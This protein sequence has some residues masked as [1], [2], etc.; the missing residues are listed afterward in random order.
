M[1]IKLFNKILPCSNCFNKKIWINHT[2][3]DDWFLECSKCHWC[4]K[5]KCL[6]IS[7]IR[8][9]NKEMRDISRRNKNG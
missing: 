1:K 4:G 8:S 2:C 3:E 5:T 6:R 9:W 7:A